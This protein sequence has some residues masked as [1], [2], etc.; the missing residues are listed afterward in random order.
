MLRIIKNV[1]RILSK[2]KG[3]L[4]VAFVLPALTVIFFTTSFSTESRSKIGVVNNDK[5][6]FGEFIIDRL[7]EL[8]G[9]DVIKVEKDENVEESLLFYKYEMVI[10]ID[11]DY[12]ED[13]I[14]G[15]L[16]KIKINEIQKEEV[17]AL[18][19]QII[20]SYSS[21]LSKICNNVDVTNIGEEEIL[22]SFKENQPK[23]E[24][25]KLYKEKSNIS[26][27]L[28]IMLYIISI[29]ASLSVSYLVDD[30]NLGTKDRILMSKISEKTYYSSMCLVFFALSSVPAIEYYALCKIMKLDFEFT[31]T[32]ILIILLLLGVLISVMLNIFFTTFIKKKQIVSLISATCL[33]PIFMLSGSFWP[34]D[35]MSNT[36]QK[37]GSFLPPRWI[38][39]SVEKLQDG[40]GIIN[41]VPEI[42]GLILVSVVL[43]LATIIFTKNKIVLIKENK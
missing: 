5:G 41:I 23:L 15:K 12:S 34:Y 18:I 35:Y 9:I 14:N 40:G 39:G 17:Q 1:L 24:L 42:I 7:D 37:I 36:L 29:T 3:F 22:K 8:D 28:G 31:Q 16:N 26:N 33:I 19:S 38:L 43:F 25:N 21:C 32:Y 27:T 2:R 11:E 30:E 10:T 20:Q 6:K 4:F 13:L